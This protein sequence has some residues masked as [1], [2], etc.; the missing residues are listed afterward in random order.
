MSSDVQTKRFAL[1]RGKD[2]AGD[3]LNPAVRAEFHRADQRV[4]DEEDEEEKRAERETS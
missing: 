3:V 2:V 1:L 4:G